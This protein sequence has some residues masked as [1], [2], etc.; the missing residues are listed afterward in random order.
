MD[1]PFDPTYL[2]DEKFA[3]DQPVCRKEDPL[4]CAVR[5]GTPTI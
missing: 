2:K 5:A 4:C 1:A 3:V